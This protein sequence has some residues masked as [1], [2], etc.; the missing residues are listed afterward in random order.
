MT[1]YTLF[2]KR[3]G[4]I[5]I[6]NLLVGLSGLI[7]LPILTKTLPIEEYGIWVQVTV[8][9]SLLSPLALLGLNSA[10]VRFLAAETDKKKIQEGFYSMA[11][12]TLFTS[13]FASILLFI[14]SEPFAASFLGDR[15]NLMLIISLIIPLVTL[16]GVC[17]SYFMAF[18]QIK[19][20]SLFTILYTYGM[21]VL[22]AYSLLSG[23][24]IFEALISVLIAETIV[25]LLMYSLIISEI[26]IKKPNFS[27]LKEYLH[28]GLPQLPE[29]ISSWTVSSSDRYI[30]G[31]FV[32]VAFVGYYS[33]AYALGGLVYM[34]IAPFASFLPAVLSK[35]YDEGKEKDVRTHLEYTLKYFL[36]LAIP[37][38]LGL[39][40]LSKPILIILSTSEIASQGYL[41]TPFVVVSIVLFGAYTVVAQILYLVK[42]TKI[43]GGIWMVAAML[44]LGL[45]F[46]FIPYFGI[47]G[48]AIT[49]LIAYSFAFILV[50]HYS[51]NYFK[52][53][54]NL[55]FI[56]KSIFAS[57]I[58]SLVIIKWSPVGMLNILI[59]TGICAVVYTIILLLLGGLKKEEIGFLRKLLRI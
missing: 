7:L 23:Y 43:I 9:I 22:V 17:F 57:I 55:S 59:V 11:I 56:L 13:L 1:D 29:C 44:N 2:T 45:N 58:M 47:I 10:M 54:M 46:M 50:S 26:G 5:G 3:I 35:L 21:V 31:Y 12:F 19:R 27:H 36:M 51:F 18:Q 15:A 28:F 37:S 42:K 38:A 34:Y 32:G 8:T 41:I 30:I 24:G 48:A 16:N 20:Y 4:L 39:S 6:A 52:F 40:L 14:L 25:F 53:N 33:P 49:T